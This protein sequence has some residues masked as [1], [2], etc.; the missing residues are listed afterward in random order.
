[1]KPELASVARSAS[2]VSRNRGSEGARPEPAPAQAA[3]RRRQ[4]LLFLGA[5]ALFAAWLGWL[6]FLATSAASP[7]VLSR[8]QFLISTIDVIAQVDRIEDGPQQL[9]VKQ[10]LWSGL[11]NQEVLANARVTVTNLN[12]CTG[13]TG[14]GD[15]IVPLVQDDGQYQ[16]PTTPRSPGY[17]P[18]PR[19][20]AGRPRIYPA[21]PQTLKQYETVPKP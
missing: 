7:I 12:R 10:V 9:N 15:Y 13:W 1:M 6:A 2:D 19:T 14:P 17:E 16:V 21:M 18:D 4:R 5:L 8:P 11:R 20:E 3:G